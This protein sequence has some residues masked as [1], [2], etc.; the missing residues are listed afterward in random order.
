M[1]EDEKKYLYGKP[2]ISWLAQTFEET[3]SD[4]TQY[5][6]LMAKCANIRFCK[7][8][9]Q[10]DDGKKQGDGAYPW[11]GASD[12]RFPLIDD[13][14]NT[15][16]ATLVEAERRAN[17]IGVP[18]E[19]SDI[20]RAGLVSNFMRWLIRGKMSE[21]PKEVE[22]AANFW[23][24]KGG[25]IAGVFWER[26]V[27]KWQEKIQLLD[28][29][30][31]LAEQGVDPQALQDPL[32]EED[33]RQLLK[34]NYPDSKDKDITKAI[35]SLRTTGEA[36]LPKSGRTI[37]KPCVRIFRKGEDIIYP[38]ASADVQDAPYVF[39][40]EYKTPQQIKEY[41]ITDKWNKSWANNVCQGYAGLQDQDYYD[42][43][44]DRN[45]DRKGL[46]LTNS[47]DKQ[48]LVRIVWAYQRLID[49]DGIPGIYET[50][51]TPGYTPDD[52]PAFAKHGLMDYR[53]KGRFPFWD[54]SRENISRNSFNSRG[55]PDNAGDFQRIIKTYFDG[56]IDRQSM[57]IDPP[58]EYV[59][60]RQV[61]ERGPGAMW[62]VMRKGEAGFGEVPQ[63]DPA[64]RDMR[65]MLIDYSRN[66]CGLVT[67]DEHAN[68]VRSKKQ[69][70]INKWLRNWQE[71][72]RM[73]FWL[74]QQY[75]DDQTT[76]R[77]MGSN[78]TEPE[79]FEKNPGEEFDF[80]LEFD[81]VSQE[82]ELQQNKVKALID[83]FSAADRNGRGDWDNLLKMGVSVIDP[84]MIEGLIKPEDQAVVD[85]TEAE[86]KLIEQMMAGFDVVMP[87]QGVNVDL[88]MQVLQKWM[89]GSE[90][91][92]AIDIQQRI[93]NTEDPLSKRVQKHVKQ[94]EFIKQQRENAEIGR[95]GVRPGTAFAR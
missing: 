54:F 3:E 21:L 35:E 73:V 80:I 30:K 28:I 84:T 49:K 76:F 5:R 72:Y 38:E 78:T 8:V 55:L 20:K 63:F 34:G 81:A 88:R 24:E 18:T 82:P 53:L 65:E 44:V 94:L 36:V 85:E 11:E 29:A 47:E 23:E 43:I 60:G 90:E 14:I 59:I 1:N 58:F 13:H 45:R 6:Q 12:L 46:F 61:P 92:P 4:L 32:F 86:N 87:D 26:Q 79:I 89:Q 16:V 74:Y 15:N 52:E 40:V 48:G 67:D 95:R 10:T 7:W 71:V 17:L 25:F 75:G 93:Q 56:E 41:V 19:G 33:F 31:L 91:I 57:S 64:T 77:V 70:N 83:L 27:L 9:G 51:F 42:D 68:E 50:I 37:N 62:P 39:R 2:D 22:L 66:Y 69:A